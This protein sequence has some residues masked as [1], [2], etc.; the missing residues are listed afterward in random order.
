MDTD[1]DFDPDV[2]GR[3]PAG[4]RGNAGNLARAAILPAPDTGATTADTA[5]GLIHVAR[6]ARAR[7]ADL[8][9]LAAA[10]ESCLDWYAATDHEV[11][12]ALDLFSAERL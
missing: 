6:L 12:W 5:G 7:A 11:G 9:D 8:D 4:L 1:I 3:L 10:I 2:I